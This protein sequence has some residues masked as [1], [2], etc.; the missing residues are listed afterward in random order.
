MA[1]V[2]SGGVHPPAVAAVRAGLFRVPETRILGDDG[3]NLDGGEGGALEGA[4]AV[5]RLPPLKTGPGLEPVAVG[6]NCQAETALCPGSPGW[7]MVCWTTEG[8][9]ARGAVPSCSSA[10]EYAGTAPP[11]TTTSAARRETAGRGIAKMVP[12]TQISVCLESALTSAAE[13]RWRG[14]AL[15]DRRPRWGRGPWHLHDRLAGRGG[16]RRRLRGTEQ[17]HELLDHV[18]RGHKH[19]PAGLRRRHKTMD[20]ETRTVQELR[21]LVGPER[22]EASATRRCPHQAGRDDG[23]AE[24]DARSGSPAW[25]RAAGG[26]AWKRERAG[27]ELYAP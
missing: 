4:G 20:C 19:L 13:R 1:P 14:S 10:T 3:V 2:E 22:V 9:A 26:A 7:L 23:R 6:W 25:E 18:V 5:K 15:V 27:G 8:A 24:C 21:A 12:L 17:H 16:S 11:T